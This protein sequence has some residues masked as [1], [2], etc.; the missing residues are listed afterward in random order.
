[1]VQFHVWL[2]QPLGSYRL[3]STPTLFSRSKWHQ[4]S[5]PGAAADSSPPARGRRAKSPRRCGS[6]C[7]GRFSPAKQPCGERGSPSIALAPFPPVARNKKQ[8][9]Q[10]G[11]PGW[12]SH[13]PQQVA[14]GKRWTYFGS[15][16]RSNEPRCRQSRCLGRGHG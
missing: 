5:A 2:N 3:F 12:K 9:S 7:L 1:M 6:Q 15:A 14:D 13:N 11:V 10:V 8:L 4:S 16:G